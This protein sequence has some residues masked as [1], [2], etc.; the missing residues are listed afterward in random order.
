MIRQLLR[1][2]QKLI[3]R[4][5]PISFVS[6]TADHLCHRENAAIRAF[7]CFATFSMPE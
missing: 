1:H 7:A 6:R 3:N 4:F 2:R 5:L